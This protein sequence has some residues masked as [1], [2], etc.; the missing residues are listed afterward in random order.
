MACRRYHD[1]LFLAKDLS[2]HKSRPD[3]TETIKVMKVK[4]E[5]TVQMVMEN[6]ITNGTS[7]AL[8]LK[9]KEYLKK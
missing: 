5:K 2:F 9:A 8:I 3:G 6:K 4:L 7:C 1:F